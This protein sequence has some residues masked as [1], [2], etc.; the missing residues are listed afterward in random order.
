M[1]SSQHKASTWVVVFKLT[2]FDDRSLFFMNVF[3]NNINLVEVYLGDL[4][5]Y[6]NIINFEFGDYI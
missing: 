4:N 3:L 1:S 6:H 5:F 2:E